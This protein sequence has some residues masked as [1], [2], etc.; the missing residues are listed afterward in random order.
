MLTVRDVQVLVHVV[1]VVTG[2]TAVTGA[3]STERDVVVVRLLVTGWGSRGVGR[4]SGAVFT[5][6][7]TTGS[8]EVPRPPSSVASIG[9][10]AGSTGCGTIVATGETGRT[11]PPRA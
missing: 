10:G 3:G 5:V 7:A 6:G 8:V 9:S 11:P 4:G 2:S 1:V